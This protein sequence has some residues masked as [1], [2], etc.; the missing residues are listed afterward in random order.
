MADEGHVEGR[1]NFRDD[2]A[3]VVRVL[4][5]QVHSQLVTVVA[6]ATSGLCDQPH[7]VLLHVLR[8]SRQGA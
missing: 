5:A 4:F 3:D 1:Y 6:H 8:V 7:R 2:D